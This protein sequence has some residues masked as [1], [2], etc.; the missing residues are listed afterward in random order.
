MQTPHKR[1][2]VTEQSVPVGKSG[3][4]SEFILTNNHNAYIKTYFADTKKHYNDIEKAVKQAKTVS[5]S[6]AITIV[7]CDHAVTS[8]YQ[9]A[10]TRQQQAQQ[11]PVYRR[12]IKIQD[13]LNPHD[14]HVTYSNPWFPNK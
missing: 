3:Y 13:L 9:P 7:E 1:H 4:Y 8:V 12:Q 5:S 11:P 14:A 10:S 2:Q 6:P